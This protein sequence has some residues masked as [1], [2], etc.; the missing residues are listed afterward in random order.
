M[1]T[2]QHLI[3][4]AITFLTSNN[5]SHAQENTKISLEEELPNQIDVFKEN[6]LSSSDI[7]QDFN[8][9]LLDIEE[10]FILNNYEDND[11]AQPSEFNSDIKTE[12]NDDDDDD[13]V[14][15]S[16][17]ENSSINTLEK[18]EFNNRPES[19]GFRGT[20][21]VKTILPN[22]KK[23]FYQKEDMAVSW[24][25]SYRAESFLSRNA[26]LL[27][28]CNVF[29][30]L[31]WSRHILDMGFNMEYGEG[32]YGEKV[33][34]INMNWRSRARWGNPTIFSTTQTRTRALDEIGRNHSHGISRMIPWLR[35]IWFEFDI[36]KA[37]DLTFMTKPKFKLGAF[38]FLVGRGIAL[39][40]AYSVGP[41][42]LGFYTDYAIDQFAFAVNVSDS[43][44]DEKLD[45]DFYV[46]ILKSNAGGLSDTGALINTQKFGYRSCPERGPFKVNLAVASRIKWHVF[47]TPEIGALDI[48]PYFMFNHDPE[49]RVEFTA[50]AESKLFTLGFATEYVGNQFE[51]GFDY[52]SNMG[53]QKVF[54]WDRNQNAIENRNGSPTIVSSHVIAN[55]NPLNPVNATNETI[56]NISKYRAINSKVTIN[57]Q[58]EIKP[59]G[60]EAQALIDTANT[61]EEFNGKPLGVIE[62]YSASVHAPVGNTELQDT[63]FN[64]KSR[65]RNSYINRYEGWMIVGDAAWW[66][67]EK[68]LRLAIT[69]GISSGDSNPNEENFDGS[70][71]GFIPLQEYYYGKRVRSVF[72]LGSG[73]RFNR[74]LS[75]PRNNLQAP[76]RFAS[77]V[78]N[79][80]NVALLGGGILWQPETE[81]TFSVNTNTIAYWQPYPGRRFDPIAN[82]DLEELSDPY[83]GLEINT[84]L[85]YYLFK[86]TKL[87]L[88]TSA[89]IPGIHFTQIKGRPINPEQEERL[90]RFNRTSIKGLPIPNIGDDAGFTFNV[91][92]DIK[93]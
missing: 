7:E 93:F 50:D 64:S 21:P 92:L 73:S 41:E 85:E 17:K 49:Q 38:P 33:F 52:A 42:F 36:S 72:F 16:S 53:R 34:E 30:R 78:N 89:F 28:S 4:L 63:L 26:S 75:Q 70:Y 37:L 12:N 2:I 62:N 57:D 83:L 54:G 88:V 8:S 40:A 56:S 48:E 29:D 84:F 43:F 77:V 14:D 35:E 23:I 60:T 20:D 55:V 90:N 66:P 91:G 79:F 86:N 59:Y 25:G 13:N 3:L 74:P 58:L 10:D 6:M 68:T 80:S 31:Y 81:K 82:K 47:N 51:F 32:T 76:S 69:S 1:I 24:F 45:F 9:D 46:A 18:D 71:G 15:L 22:Y 44:L 27:N 87:Y 65:F 61:G 39:G 19:L 67:V 11:D 5:Y